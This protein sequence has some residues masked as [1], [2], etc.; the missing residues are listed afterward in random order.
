[1]TLGDNGVLGTLAA[2]AI[3]AVSSTDMPDTVK[4]LDAKARANGI[5]VLV[6]PI[7]RG[8]FFADE[9][10]LLAEGDPWDVHSCRVRLA[11]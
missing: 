6:A 1:M 8:R 3:V 4:A 7:C 9:G 10:K 5:D 2:G 11:R